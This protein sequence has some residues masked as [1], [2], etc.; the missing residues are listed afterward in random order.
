MFTH[1]ELPIRTWWIYSDP[2]SREW[3]CAVRARTQKDA[4]A[5]ARRVYKLDR[6]AR[7]YAPTKTEIAIDMHRA[8]AGVGGYVT[9]LPP[10]CVMPGAN[11]AA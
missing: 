7:A 9:P 6:G 3:F 11:A 4:L 8:L 2:K 5:A 10:G 1:T